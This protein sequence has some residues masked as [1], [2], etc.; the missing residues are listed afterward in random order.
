VVNCNCSGHHHQVRAV[1]RGGGAGGQLLH[2]Q[3]EEVEIFFSIDSAAQ[4]LQVQIMNTIHIFHQWKI[5]IITGDKLSIEALAVAIFNSVPMDLFLASHS[6]REFQFCMQEGFTL[7]AGGGTPPSRTL[8]SQ[9]LRPRDTCS[10]PPIIFFL[11]AVQ[12]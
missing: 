12:T 2:P 7:H 10:S 5:F 6:R 3:P 9:W 1:F 4:Q 11:N 8:H